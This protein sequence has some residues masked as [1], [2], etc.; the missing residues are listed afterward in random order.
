MAK[1]FSNK[2]IIVFLE[3]IDF[4]IAE[5]YAPGFP[6]Y[7]KKGKFII[8]RFIN[9]FKKILEINNFE[10]K[11]LK[12]SQMIVLQDFK[13]LY[14]GINDYADEI[15]EFE[16]KIISSDP[17]V[18]TLC[19]V[20]QEYANILSISPI[21]RE[22]SNGL[23]P[24]FKDRYIF[25]VIQIDQRIKPTYYLNNIY[26]LQQIYRSFYKRI[27]LYF[28]LLEGFEVKKYADKELYF[29]GS[30]DD[31]FTKLGMIYELSKKFNR[32][33]QITLSDI[34]LNSGLSGKTLFLSIKNFSEFYGTLSIP[35]IICENLIYVFAK[36]DSYQINFS[37]ILSKYK[38][39]Y[40][41]GL[42]EKH[43]FKK[44][45]KSEA[46]YYIYIKKKQYVLIEKNGQI[47]SFTSEDKVIRF[48]ENNLKY[49][50]QG[51]FEHSRK[52]LHENLKGNTF[53]ICED[54]YSDDIYGFIHEDKDF[55]CLKCGKSIRKK[56]F[57]SD[58]RFY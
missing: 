44:W 9:L 32:N 18:Q 31:K 30:L 25:P 48:I 50:E 24:L 47:H 33:Y 3:Q 58:K 29:I 49:L 10:Y 34:L 43:F 11:Q 45:Q 12:V 19:Q 39:S 53:E 56:I 36:D 8:N 6:I 40:C 5:G 14:N 13:K 16:D 22:K 2:E 4:L 38:D 51:A 27:G 20:K 26:K 55:C 23:L 15:V 21:Y 42:S 35:P 54:C 17:L 57:L 37:K 52:K 1:N 7:L 41:V 46:F 28:L